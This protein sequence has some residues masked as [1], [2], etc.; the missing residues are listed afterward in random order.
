MVV[1]NGFS[2]KY[3]ITI[4]AFQLNTIEKKSAKR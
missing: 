1:E 3:K 4:L 2:F